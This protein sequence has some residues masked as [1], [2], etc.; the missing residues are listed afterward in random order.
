MKRIIELQTEPRT[1]VLGEDQ[2]HPQD[3]EEE[4]KDDDQEHSIPDDID[5]PRYLF[6]SNLDSLPGYTN[7]R[8]Q[9]KQKRHYEEFVKET[10][11]I[12]RLF[13]NKERKYDSKLVLYVCQLAEHYFSKPKSGPVKEEAVIQSVKGFYNDDECLVK[14]IIDLVLP[15]IQKSNVV[16]RLRS[17]TTTFFFGILAALVKR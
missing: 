8:K 11:K 16:R 2:I 17:K 15:N 7:I 14:S 5:L 13:S 1:L 3:E 9:L 4:P 10:R 6:N 12:L